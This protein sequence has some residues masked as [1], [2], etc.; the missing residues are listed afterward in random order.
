MFG[1]MISN[2]MIKPGVSPVF[3]H[4][5]NHDLDYEDVSF[6][7]ANET[8]LRGWLIKGGTDK[9]VIQTHFGVQCSRAG[10]TPTGKGLIKMWPENISFLRQAKHLTQLG[11]SVLMYDLSNHGESDPGSCPWISWGPNEAADVIAA[12]QF[13]TEH[14][15]YRNASIGLLS[16]C[17]G[18]VASTYAYGMGDD[19]LRRSPNVKAMISVQ[20]LHYNEFVKAFGIP[21]FMNRQGLKISK[22]RLGFDLAGKTFMQAVPSISVPTLVLQN[23]NDPWTDIAFVRD[24]FNRLTTEKELLLPKLSNKRAAA[25]DYLVTHPRVISDFFSPHL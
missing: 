25:Y 21:A 11:Y 17:M 13:I 4:P 24:Y 12:V 18:A 1:T 23:E 20:P 22:E 5:N 16:I 8:T 6:K 2:M 3:D 15:N 10:Y 19:G 7:N 14:P 9:L